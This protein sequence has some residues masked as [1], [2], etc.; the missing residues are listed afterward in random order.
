MMNMDRIHRD[1]GEIL[2]YSSNMIKSNEELSWKIGILIFLER[3]LQEKFRKSK[4][5]WFGFIFIKKSRNEIK[6][7]K[8]IAKRQ[9]TL[10]NHIIRLIY[11]LKL[12]S[13]TT[14]RKTMEKTH[15]LTQN[16]TQNDPIWL[17]YQGFSFHILKNKNPEFKRQILPILL[18][19]SS[20]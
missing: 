8:L 3:R 17:P 20:F 4:I 13:K 10:K 1:L 5:A 15:N 12:K 19:K 6:V 2:R 18:S 14:R 9:K 16:H 11:C 7:E